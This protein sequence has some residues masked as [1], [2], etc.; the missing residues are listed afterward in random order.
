[1][2]QDVFRAIEEDIRQAYALIMSAH[3]RGFQEADRETLLV[4][5]LL[6]EAQRNLV[7]ALQE[8]RLKASG[9]SKTDAA[10]GP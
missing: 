7:D 8:L 1:M 4:R 6:V 9:G 10:G 2:D 5:Q 3:D